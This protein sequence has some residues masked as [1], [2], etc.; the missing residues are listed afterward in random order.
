MEKSLLTIENHHAIH[1]KFNYKWQCS[2]AMLDY[3]I[4]E[5]YRKSMG[6]EKYRKTIGNPSEIGGLPS[7]KR[8]HSYGK[9]PY[10]WEIQL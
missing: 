6:W 4:T 10:S 2:I 7:E 9:S 8:L 1:F 3:M 5:K